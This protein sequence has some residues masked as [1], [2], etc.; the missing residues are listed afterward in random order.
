MMKVVYDDKGS[1]IDT[2]KSVL[3]IKD[4]YLIVVIF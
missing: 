3:Y 4:L 1:N 2:K